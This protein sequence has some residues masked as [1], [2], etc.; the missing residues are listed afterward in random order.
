ME[1]H[2]LNSRFCTICK[3]FRGWNDELGWICEAFPDGIPVDI[4]DYDFDHRD[5]YPGDNDIQFEAFNG[6][7]YVE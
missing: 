6:P 3:H 4:A 5:P 1:F 7:E 2:D